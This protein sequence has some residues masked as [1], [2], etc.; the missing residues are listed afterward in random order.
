MWICKL[1]N[2][3]SD[4]DEYQITWNVRLIICRTK[5]SGTLEGLVVEQSVVL[6]N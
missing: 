1:T 3:M 4:F 5:V 2:K 6:E